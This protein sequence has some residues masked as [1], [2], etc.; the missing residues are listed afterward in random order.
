MIH[1]IEIVFVFKSKQLK[2]SYSD[3]NKQKLEASRRK[4]E[5]EPKVREVQSKQNLGKHDYQIR[6]ESTL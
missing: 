1:N 5:I 4:P 2:I 6:I 3:E